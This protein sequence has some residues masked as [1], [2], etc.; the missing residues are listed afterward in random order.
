M[1]LITTAGYGSDNIHTRTQQSLAAATAA[2]KEKT[3]ETETQATPAASD[4]VT[5]S[6]QVRSA[7][8]RELMGLNP[9]GALKLQD[10]GDVAQSREKVVN[11][12]LDQAT[13]SLGIDPKQSMTLTLD[14]KGEVTIP[15]NFAGK[16]DLEE[17]LN[18]DKTFVVAFNQMSAN[19]EI[20]TQVS[21]L[22]KGTTSL[23]DVM[24]STADWND[25]IS[26]AQRH[27][28]LQ[29]SQDPLA[30]LTDLGHA[31]TPYTH[32]YPPE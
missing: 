5:L 22:G 26:L 24:N 23:A 15:E 2:K 10:F 8:T 9:T 13:Q 30:T 17:A 19:T 18:Q 28:K 29:N 3:T 11:A 7:R 31:E 12:T 6:P 14:A 20:L 32:T 16:N 25:I 1:S 4:R 27:K 21:N